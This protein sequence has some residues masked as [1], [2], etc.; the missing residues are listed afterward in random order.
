MSDDH[1]LVEPVGHA[2]EVLTIRFNRPEKKNAIP[3]NPA[4]YLTLK[5]FELICNQGVASS[6][7]AGGTTLYHTR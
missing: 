6:S 2:P 3:C 4:K 5:A 1:I 7:L